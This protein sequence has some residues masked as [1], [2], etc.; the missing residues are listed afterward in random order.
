MNVIKI[1]QLTKK[2]KDI[3]ALD[4]INMEVEEHTLHG[5]LG[6]NGAGKSTLINILTGLIKKTSGECY[7]LGYNLDTNL[8][9]IKRITDVSPQEVSIGLNLTVKE[10]LYFFASIYDLTDNIDNII[11]IFGLSEVINQKAKTLSGGWKRRVS[12]AIAMLSNPQILFLDEPT[13]GLDVVSRRQLWA[14]IKTLKTKTTI[15]LT[16]HYLEEIENLC[17]KV[18]ILAKGQVI[19]TSTVNDIKNLTNSSNFE[20]AFVKLVEEV[21]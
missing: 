14:I 10:N 18:T 20:D 13:L 9:E 7:I 15:V 17:D 4:N 12:I 3:I 2:Y 19:T 8:N 1:S 6:V 11:E 21:K 16:S 5:L